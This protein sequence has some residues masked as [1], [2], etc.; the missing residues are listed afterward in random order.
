M[1]PRSSAFYAHS[2]RVGSAVLLAPLAGLAAAIPLSFVYG[3][4]LVYSPV[5]GYV[6][7]LFLLGLGYGLGKP[8]AVAARIGKCRSRPFL[9]ATGVLTG[10]FALYL[11][12]AVFVFALFSRYDETFSGSLLQVAAPE[13]L[14]E[15]ISGINADG[16]YTIAGITPSGI[17]LWGFWAVEAAVTVG[18]PAW[19]AGDAITDAVFCERC[20]AWCGDPKPLAF[21]A[22]PA[23][24]MTLS[25]LREGSIDALERLAAPEGAMGT[26]LV[27]DARRC[28]T[29]QTMGVY[30]IRQHTRSIG[31]DG[32]VELATSMVSPFVR[33]S[34]EQIARIS[35]IGARAEAA[36]AERNGS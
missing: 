30:R 3:Y 21:L 8:I 23:D 1:T 4:L 18:F 12:W 20:A 26:F 10:A 27:V 35:A 13:V 34:E 22:A 17:L 9:L 5:V 7:F 14:W 2:G 31:K 15:L 16:W 28:A 19:L 29:C 24:E 11:S 33:G 32:G 36:A 25:S 6:N